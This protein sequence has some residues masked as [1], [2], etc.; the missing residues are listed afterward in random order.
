MHEF[1]YFS[2]ENCT[3]HQISQ[4]LSSRIC[5]QM[6]KGS[7]D[8][9][10]NKSRCRSKQFNWNFSVLISFPHDC[11]C[12]EN[13]RA[14]F[15]GGG[16]REATLES[17]RF[18]SSIISLMS[19]PSSLRIFLFNNLLIFLKS[20]WIQDW[21]CCVRFCLKISTD[22]D[23]TQIEITMDL[24]VIRNKRMTREQGVREGNKKR[25]GVD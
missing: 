2:P 25:K 12:T 1:S 15:W 20:N 5:L 9:R 17:Q 6:L 22:R 4:A 14:F 23:V 11:T 24:A 16:G 7:S 3:F 8:C 18:E 13:W 19:L 10:E 21:M